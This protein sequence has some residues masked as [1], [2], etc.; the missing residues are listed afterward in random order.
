MEHKI[1]FIGFGTVGRG[2]V[3]ILL[4]KTRE[5]KNELG[6]DW[7]IVAISDPRVGSVCTPSGLAAAAI[8][9]HLEKHGNLEGFECETA[10][11]DSLKTISDSGA[12]I[13]VEASYSN[14]EDGEPALSHIRKALAAGKHVVTTNKGPLV[15]AYDDLVTL[16][17]DN[18]VL[19]RHEGTVLSGTPVFSLTEHCLQCNNILGIR[20]IL[21]GTTNYILCEMEKGLDYKTALKHAQDAGYAEASPGADVDGIDS[22][23]KTLI[24]AQVLMNTKLDIRKVHTEG[25]SGITAEDIEKAAEEGLRYKLVSSINKNGSTVSASVKLEQLP[26]D[27]PLAAVEGATNAITFVTELLDET[28]IIGAGA[29]KRPTGYALLHDIIEIHKLAVRNK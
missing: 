13:I 6:F 1:A 10:G 24:L 26:F 12:D 19:F 18:S 21:N 17:K 9:P 8:L 25:I 2:L 11:M 28:T 14:M 20:G 29:G 16:A 4:D 3:E 23:A 7:K 5:L 15:H 27:D 22:L